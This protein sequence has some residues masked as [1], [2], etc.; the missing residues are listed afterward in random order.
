MS[1]DVKWI[2]IVTDIFDD[3]KMYAI[4]SLPD[5]MQIEIVWFKILCLAGKCN[6]GGLLSISNKIAYTDEMLAKIFRMEIGTVKRAI[7]VFQSLEMVELEDN[8]YIVSNWSKYQNQDALEAI[9][10]QN[11]ERQKRFRERRK[12]KENNVTK[13]LENNVNCSI[14]SSYSYSYSNNSNISNLSYVLDNNI[15]TDSKYILENGDLHECLEE[16]MQYKDGRKPK[17][18][19]HYGTEIGIK[20]TITQFVSAYREYGMDALKKIV[21]DSMA[22]NYA[23][24]IWDR[25]NRFQKNSK[26]VTQKR[27]EQGMDDRFACLEP[28]FRKQLEE[29]GAIYGDQ[30]LDYG[31]LSEHPDWLKI[32]QESGV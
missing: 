8:A 27:D 28:S 29:A 13:A 15:H 17:S 32:I 21:D 2:K 9:K 10:K 26:P 11:R 1:G 3:E 25:L 30:S 24:V 16:W 18:S 12:E 22:N 14:S 20:K 23:G 5:G 4:E 7:E 19:N 6:Q 31:I